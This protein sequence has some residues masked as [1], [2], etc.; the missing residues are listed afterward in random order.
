MVPI[1]EAQGWGK[2]QRWKRPPGDPQ[3]YSESS[4]VG[5]PGGHLALPRK[6]FGITREIWTPYCVGKMKESSD[7][8]DLTGVMLEI[9]RWYSVS[10]TGEAL[11][12]HIRVT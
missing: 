3:V 2:M 9:Q 5:R 10:D 11:K 6:D 7:E 8:G 4:E 12:L 1:C